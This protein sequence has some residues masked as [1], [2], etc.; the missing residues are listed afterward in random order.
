MTM[1]YPNLKCVIMRCVIKGLHCILSGL[2]SY[3]EKKR[4]IVYICRAKILFHQWAHLRRLYCF[5]MT[6]HQRKL[7]RQHHNI[8]FGEESE[9]LY[10]KFDI[11]SIYTATSLFEIDELYSRL[12]NF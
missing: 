3:F 9:R 2:E 7:I 12:V 1:L 4:I 10:G 6:L 5:G 11:D 8:L